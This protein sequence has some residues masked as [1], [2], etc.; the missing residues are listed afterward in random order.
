MKVSMKIKFDS[1]EVERI[2]IEEVERRMGPAPDGT[3][4]AA[5]ARYANI[6]ACVVESVEIEPEE[7]KKEDGDEG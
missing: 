7:V 1:D 2:L 5:Y 6:L 4:Y 3:K